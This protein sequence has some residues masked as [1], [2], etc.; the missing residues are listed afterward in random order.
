MYVN[1]WTCDFGIRGRASVKL[2]LDEAFDAGLI[3][4]RIVAEF[5]TLG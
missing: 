2:F 3:P 5:V 4:N 1:D